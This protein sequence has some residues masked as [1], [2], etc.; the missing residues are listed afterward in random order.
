MA[1]R[2]EEEFTQAVNDMHERE[3]HEDDNCFLVDDKLKAVVQQGPDPQETMSSIKSFNQAARDRMHVCLK[4]PPLKVRQWVVFL[5]TISLAVTQSRA[6]MLFN[7][8]SCYTL[9]VVLIFCV[10][11]TEAS[12]SFV[13]WSIFLLMPMNIVRAL[14]IYI[15]LGRILNITDADLKVFG[16]LML[17]RG[18]DDSMMTLEAYYERRKGAVF[19]TQTN[20][21]LDVELEAGNNLPA[22]GRSPLDTSQ[23]MPPKPGDQ[24]GL[25][26][27][28]HVAF[29]P[30]WGQVVGLNATLLKLSPGDFRY[31]NI[32]M[33]PTDDLSLFASFVY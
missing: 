13:L 8:L 31:F 15:V 12:E 16:D 19:A 6:V 23:S 33:D 25:K 20:P 29:D 18:A 22:N 1:T 5:R 21:I 30:A 24:M 26:A 3:L 2:I 4:Q 14:D 28:F 11:S 7:E 17:G 10:K 27:T 9:I 32:Q